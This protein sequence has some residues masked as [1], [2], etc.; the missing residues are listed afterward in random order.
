VRACN[1]SSLAGGEQEDGEFEA[2]LCKICKTTSKT[3]NKNKRAGGVVQVVGHLPNI[4]KAQYHTH[5][6][7]LSIYLSSIYL[8]ARQ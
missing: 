3:Q 7:T 2:S 5:T 6:H 4:H 8:C 1:S